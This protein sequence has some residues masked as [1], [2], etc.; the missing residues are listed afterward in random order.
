MV[1]EYEGRTLVLVMTKTVCF[2]Y[3]IDADNKHGELGT[4]VIA[5]NATYA[6]A[7]QRTE[8]LYKKFNP[9]VTFY[10]ISSTLVDYFRDQFMMDLTIFAPIEVVNKLEEAYVT[11]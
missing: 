5:G 7:M 11:V 4:H 6:E 10:P 8:D 3:I 9:V 2:I 1:M